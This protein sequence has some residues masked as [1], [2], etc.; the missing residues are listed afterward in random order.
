MTTIAYRD[1]ILAGDTLISSGENRVGYGQKIRQKGQLLYA[2]AGSAGLTEK[3]EAWIRSGCIGENPP[4]K[5]GDATGETF[6]FMPDD[7]I[8]WF[9][10][11]GSTLIRAKFFARGSGGEYALGAMQNGATAIEAVKCAMALDRGTGGTVQ[12]IAR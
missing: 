5:S 1:G 9:H 11:D 10:C 12:W 4:L 7:S 8:V 3:V 6:L 2:S